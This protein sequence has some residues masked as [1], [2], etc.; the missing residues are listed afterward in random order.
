MALFLVALLAAC[1][2][3]YSVRNSLAVFAIHSWTISQFSMSVN[4]YDL[5]QKCFGGKPTVVSTS[6][7][8]WVNSSVIG[9]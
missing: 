6:I 5:R 9:S 3:F 4:L 1:G 8:I 2:K 7:S